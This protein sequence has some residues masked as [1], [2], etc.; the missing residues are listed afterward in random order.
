MD[1][2]TILNRFTEVKLEEDVLKERLREI[3]AE[4]CKLLNQ[5]KEIN[6]GDINRRMDELLPYY[7]EYEFLKKNLEEAKEI[8]SLTDDY[9]DT[10]TDKNEDSFSVNI[11]EEI[12]PEEDVYLDNDALS[13]NTSVD[14]DADLPEENKVVLTDEKTDYSTDD[15]GEENTDADECINEDE[16]E[17]DIANNLDDNFVDEDL[18]DDD[19]EEYKTTEDKAENNTELNTDT[20]TQNTDGNTDNSEDKETENEISNKQRRVFKDLSI[21]EKKEYLVSMADLY[22]SKVTEIMEFWNMQDNPDEKNKG[23][24]ILR[25]VREAKGKIYSEESQSIIEEA[26]VDEINEVL[27][28]LRKSKNDIE[29]YAFEKNK[30]EVNNR[31]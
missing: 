20:N 19:N 11:T 8:D 1:L 4:K 2:Q 12:V 28:S 5:L 21:E 14:E 10:N 6:K 22:R 18:H 30:G 26:G 16:I 25:E 15:S 31:F 23:L 29:A 27:L 24:T 3:R 17:E 9:T 13:Y 7:L